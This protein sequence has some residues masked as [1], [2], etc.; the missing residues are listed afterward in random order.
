MKRGFIIL[1]LALIVSS[2]FP[3]SSIAKRPSSNSFAVKNQ[4][5]GGK[6]S[7]GS[8][9]EGYVPIADGL[10]LYYRKAGRGKQ[11]ILVPLRLFLF[12]DFKQLADQYTVIS[13]D[14]RNR[15]L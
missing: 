7:M 9:E 8:F 14:T 1:S 6:Q 4:E 10:R 2:V 5:E 11:V 15:G 3:S 12:D 13:F